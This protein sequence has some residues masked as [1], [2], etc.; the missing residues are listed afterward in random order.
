MCD[1]TSTAPFAE[2]EF[3]IVGHRAS[4][5][6][7]MSYCVLSNFRNFAFLVCCAGYIESS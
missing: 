1:R 3:T 4:V 7:R 2:N 5:R 6:S